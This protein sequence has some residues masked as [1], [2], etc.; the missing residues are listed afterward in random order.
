MLLCP[1]KILVLSE[2]V[3]NGVKADDVNGASHPLGCIWGVL[4]LVVINGHVMWKRDYSAFSEY[5][6]SLF[7]F[8]LSPSVLLPLPHSIVAMIRIAT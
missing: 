5:L 7:T 6:P 3:A 8:Q 2:N 1:L 4:G